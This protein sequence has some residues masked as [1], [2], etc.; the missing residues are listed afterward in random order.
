MTGKYSKYIKEAY[1]INGEGQKVRDLDLAS[2]EIVDNLKAQNTNLKKGKE[3][4]LPV[5][6]AP[7]TMSTGPSICRTAAFCC[8]SSPSRIRFPLLLLSID[9]Q[10]S[11]FF[12]WSFANIEKSSAKD[13]P[14]RGKWGE[15]NIFLSNFA[16]PNEIIFQFIS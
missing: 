8:G 4:E 3:V 6:P 7:A 12:Y 2:R 15:F 14:F 1:T 5:D 13:L 16:V 9:W 11:D 10:K